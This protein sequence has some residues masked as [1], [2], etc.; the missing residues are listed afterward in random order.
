MFLGDSSVTQ[1]LSYVTQGLEGRHKRLKL[2]CSIL[3]SGYLYSLGPMFSASAMY[4]SKLLPTVSV[5]VS[6]LTTAHY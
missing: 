2:D 1:G 4:M 6:K 3:D 5:P